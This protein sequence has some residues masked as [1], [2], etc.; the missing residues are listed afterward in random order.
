M[1]REQLKAMRNRAMRQSYEDNPRLRC[2]RYQL[3]ACLRAGDDLMAFWK[4]PTQALKDEL[5][6]IAE[7]VR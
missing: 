2:I 5:K 3:E 4:L 1:T 6:R 7:G